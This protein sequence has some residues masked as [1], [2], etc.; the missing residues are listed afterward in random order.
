MTLTGLDCLIECGVT[1]ESLALAL[2]ESF[3]IPPDSIVMHRELA[4]RIDTVMNSTIWACVHAQSDDSRWRYMIDID[5]KEEW[6]W[7]EWQHR[8]SDLANHLGG[9]VWY[10]DESQCADDAMLVVYPDGRFESV[11]LDPVARPAKVDGVEW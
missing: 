3:G 10:C 8:M 6:P 11:Q 4:A 5:G 1:A 2:S 7:S 9:P